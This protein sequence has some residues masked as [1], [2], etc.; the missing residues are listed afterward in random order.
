MGIP[1]KTLKKSAALYN[2]NRACMQVNSLYPQ[3]NQT[4][5]LAAMVT[6]I[7]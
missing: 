6:G 1:V 4:R 5:P 3:K 2:P 7:P